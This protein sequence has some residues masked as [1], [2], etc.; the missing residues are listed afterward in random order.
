M[1]NPYI[2]ILRSRG[3]R[4]TKCRIAIL[5]A[6]TSGKLPVSAAELQVQLSKKRILI[7]KTTIYRELYALRAA[8]II[9]EMSLGD[10]QRRYE[11]I[12]QA[13]HHHHLVCVNCN[14]IE[15]INVREDLDAEENR[16]S[17]CKK[18]KVLSHSLEFFGVCKS[19]VKTN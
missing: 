8:G 9:K 12:N 16:I 18:F 17:K 13:N 14:H 1:F 7:N 5:E 10:K 3:L 19:C 6:V 4:T 2:N 15:D 11:F